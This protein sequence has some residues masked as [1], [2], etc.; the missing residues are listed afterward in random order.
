MRT[1]YITFF[2][3]LLATAGFAQAIPV[4]SLYLGQITTGNI[5]EMFKLDVSPGHFAAERIAISDDG[6]EIYYSEIKSYYPI[7]SA[8]IKSY[9]FTDGKWTDPFVLFEGYC[10]PALSATGDTMYFE[11]GT[12]EA[13]FSV[14][15]NL[16]WSAPLRI[17]S[18][19]E[20]AHYMQVTSKGNQYIS[21]KPDETIG[22]SDWCKLK[23]TASDTIA[24]GL[25]MPLNTAWDNLDF[26]VSK[27][28]SF[29]IVTTPF[30][31]AISYP[32][33]D[34][35]WT[36]PRNLG[37]KINFGLG[38]WGPFVTPDNK[39]L[40]YTT[41]TK[42]DYSDVNEYWIRID[43]LIDSLK[44]TNIPPYAKNKIKSPAGIIGQEYS[45]TIPDD[46]FFDEDGST[47]FTFTATQLDG[48]PLPAWLSFNALTKT[49]SG[50]PTEAA[51]LKILVTATDTGNDSGI[52]AF[53]LS[54]IDKL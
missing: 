23:F 13:Y 28:E 31:L 35:T 6:R 42:P 21:S 9:G 5:P 41:G 43:G 18:K 15:K 4:D 34:G 49:F 29:I 45:F 39:Y 50:T 25:G 22:I 48:Y 30:G 54:V 52:A 51:E 40:F 1:N 53:K 46:T 36:N 12:A 2:L 33:S 47:S 10:S 20:T 44:H 27:D 24:I 3:L 19:L 16:K 11:N 37:A 14:K 7:N 8:R 17:L 38:M 26:F 32:K